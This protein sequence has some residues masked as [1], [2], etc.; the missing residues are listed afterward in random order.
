VYDANNAHLVPP[1]VRARV[2]VLRED[3]VAGRLR[4][5]LP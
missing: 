2:E 1:A 5:E 4:V 3:L